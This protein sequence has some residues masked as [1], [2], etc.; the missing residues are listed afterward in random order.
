MDGA[1]S[2]VGMSAYKVDAGYG[3]GCLQ[4]L[5]GCALQS[6]HRDVSLV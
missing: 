3:E 6:P 5:I 4:A 1:T 2:I